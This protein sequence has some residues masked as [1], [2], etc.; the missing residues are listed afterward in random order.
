MKRIR[1]WMPL[2]VIDRYPFLLDDLCNCLHLQDKIF[3]KKIM[4][5]IHFYQNTVK[6]NL[7][8]TAEDENIKQRRTVLNERYIVCR[9]LIFKCPAVREAS[10]ECVRCKFYLTGKRKRRPVCLYSQYKVAIMLTCWH[11]LTNAHVAHG[12]GRRERGKSIQCILEQTEREMWRKCVQSVNW[13]IRSSIFFYLTTQFTA[14]GFP[15]F[16]TS[17]E[18]IFCY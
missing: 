16:V 18:K 11:T 13:I 5:S 15:Y 17:L 10:A 7:P 12:N 1:N 6:M 3:N 4:I 9:C 2:Q 14:M 8:E